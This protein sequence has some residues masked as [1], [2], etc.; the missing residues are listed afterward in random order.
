MKENAI[1]ESTRNVSNGLAQKVIN[2]KRW[3]GATSRSGRVACPRSFVFAQRKERPERGQATLPDLRDIATAQFF[4]DY[5]VSNDF[6]CKAGLELRP[7]FVMLRV[8]SWIAFG[9]SKAAEPHLHCDLDSILR[10]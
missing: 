1:H 4:N 5:E 7:L 8:I 3:L 10:P 6:L 2:S 9:F